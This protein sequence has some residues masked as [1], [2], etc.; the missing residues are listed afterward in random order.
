MQLPDTA[1]ILSQGSYHHLS[2]L[3]IYPHSALNS[4][5]YLLKPH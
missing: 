5:V 2:T 1:L 4:M 3:H